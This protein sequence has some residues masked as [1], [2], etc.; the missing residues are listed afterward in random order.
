MVMK[1]FVVFLVLLSCSAG[2]D[3]RNDALPTTIP[4]NKEIISTNTTEI[5]G[6]LKIDT[7]ENIY[8]KNYLKETYYLSKGENS[9]SAMSG[10]MGERLYFLEVDKVLSNEEMEALSALSIDGFICEKTF[11]KDVEGYLDRVHPFKKN[12]TATL[13]TNVIVQITNFYL[14]THFI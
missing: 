2:Y 14:A 12:I 4:E 11:T 13:L 10:W 5:D 1:K 8:K 7:F 6:N 9:V 3:V